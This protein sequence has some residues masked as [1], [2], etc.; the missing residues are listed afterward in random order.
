MSSSA[1]DVTKETTVDVET[2]KVEMELVESGLID[3]KDKY[4]KL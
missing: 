3:F 2:L 4:K 1:I